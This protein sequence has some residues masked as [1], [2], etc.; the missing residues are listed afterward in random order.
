MKCV[1]GLGNPGFKYRYTLHN[2]GYLVVDRVARKFK[3]R[4]N[5]KICNSYIGIGNYCREKV[6]LAKPL[7]FMNLSGNAYLSLLKH[8]KIALNDILVVC[9]DIYLNFGVLKMKPAGGS[10]GHRGLESIREKLG[11]DNFP[12]LR[13]GVGPLP[14]GMKQADYVLHRFNKKQLKMLKRLLDKACLAIESWI[15]SG[16]IRAMN[17][18]NTKN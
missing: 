1:F 8:Y 3:I 2:I 6:I 16:I 4:F 12:R 14:P 9:D 5:E 17:L 10:G 13:I 11:A 7:T 15:S 18:Y